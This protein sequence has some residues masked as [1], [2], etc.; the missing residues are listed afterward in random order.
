[1]DI[2]TLLKM[3]TTNRNKKEETKKNF[4]DGKKNL[5]MIDELKNKL[6][7]NTNQDLL[8]ARKQQWGNLSDSA[9]EQFYWTTPGIKY[10]EVDD[11]SKIPK[12]GRDVETN[13]VLPPPSNFLLLLLYPMEVKYLCLRDNYSQFD[14]L[15]VVKKEDVEE[16]D[17]DGNLKS[18][19]G[20]GV[21]KNE[22]KEVW[23]STRV[24][25]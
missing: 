2:E 18:E 6:Q 4:E 14:Q 20:D 15:A 17:D 13:K 25:P 23:K 19:Q 9:R 8:I 11:D 7:E 1:M 12:G 16:N 21:L 10:T 22:K 5:N 3:D 24:N